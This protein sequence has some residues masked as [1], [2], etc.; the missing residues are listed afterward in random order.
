[1]KRMN[2]GKK[3]ALVHIIEMLDRLERKLDKEG[4]ANV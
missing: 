4:A 1:M 2:E 3:N